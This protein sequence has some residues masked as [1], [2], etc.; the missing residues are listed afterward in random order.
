MALR[1]VFFLV[2]AGLGLMLPGIVLDWLVDRRHELL[3]H[4]LPDALDLLVV[5]VEAGLGLDQALR[6]VCEELR[7]THPAL[8]D[9]L[10]LVNF[11]TR[12]GVRRMDALHHLAERTGESEI[13]K[14]VAILVQTERFGT[15]VADSLRV[16]SDFMRVRRRQEAEERAGQLGVKLIILVFLFILP[17]MFI[18]TAGP[19]ILL[20][21]TKLFPALQGTQ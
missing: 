3:R 14:L 10:A 12:T 9:E 1:L 20:L 21:F 11:E 8:C 15:S 4:S 5:C 18:V 7:L 19:S 6:N 17:A 16:H 13:S 2:P